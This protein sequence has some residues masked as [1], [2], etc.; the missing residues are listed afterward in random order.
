MSFDLGEQYYEVDLMALNYCVLA[1]ILKLVPGLA[2]YKA[3][4]VQR[5]LVLNS[6]SSQGMKKPKENFDRF[7]GFH[8]NM[9][10]HSLHYIRSVLRFTENNVGNV[11]LELI[12]PKININICPG[13]SICGDKIAQN[14]IKE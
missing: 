6:T 4:S 11:F 13:L 7:D 8:D 5:I 9:N 2:A 12:H 10:V 14:V 1:E 3:C